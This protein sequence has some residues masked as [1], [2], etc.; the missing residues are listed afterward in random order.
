MHEQVGGGDLFHAAAEGGGRETIG[1]HE[2]ARASKMLHAPDGEGVPRT[3]TFL[4]T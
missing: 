1:Y 3:Y 4:H 2:E